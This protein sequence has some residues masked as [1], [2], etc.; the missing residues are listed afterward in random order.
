MKRYLILFCLFSAAPLHAG[1]A[2]FIMVGYMQVQKATLQLGNN[3]LKSLSG[4]AFDIDGDWPLSKQISLVL[5]SGGLT[6]E[7][8]KRESGIE[9]TLDI[10][11]S[12]FG[13]LLRVYT[14]NPEAGR[15]RCYMEIGPTFN[16]LKVDQK[17]AGFTVDRGTEMKLG[18]RGNIGVRFRI[19]KRLGFQVSGGY[20]LIAKRGDVN[21]SGFSALGG[22]GYYWR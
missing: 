6:A 10:R 7:S 14:S 2:V 19:I 1:E 5:G 15:G 11:N 4:F 20:R 16:W 18:L 21:M 3:E 9:T 8:W 17:T 13:T 12:Y 22:L